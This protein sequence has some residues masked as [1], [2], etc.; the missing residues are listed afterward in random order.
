M[1]LRAK[2]V[3]AG[4]VIVLIPMLLSTIMMWYLIRRQN[5]KDALHR[6]GQLLEMIR[7]NLEAQ[8]AELLEGMKQFSLDKTFNNQ[9]SLVNQL[10]RKN[11]LVRQQETYKTEITALLEN[12]SRI[13]GY[14][15]LGVF[16]AEDSLFSFIKVEDQKPLMAI[17]S[18]DRQGEIVAKVA[19]SSRAFEELILDDWAITDLGEI[20]SDVLASPAHPE[21][22]HRIDVFENHLVLNVSVPIWDYHEDEADQQIGSLVGYRY[23]DQRLLSRLARQLQAE[24]NFFVT[25]RLYLGTLTEFEEIPESRHQGLQ[26]LV[27]TVDTTERPHLYAEYLKHGEPFYQA[28]LPLVRNEAGTIV[29][30]LVVSLSK[31]STYQNTREVIVLLAWVSCVCL[32]VVV[33]ITFIVTGRFARPIHHIAVVSDSISQGCIDHHIEQIRSQDE[34]G[35]LSRSFHEMVAYLREMAEIATHI[36]HGETVQDLSPTTEQD[37]LGTAF[38]RMITYFKHIVKIAERMHRG[39]LTQRVAVQ[40]TQDVLGAAFNNVIGQLQS[41]VR[42]VR[43]ESRQLADVSGNVKSASEESSRNSLIQTQSVE[44][45][46]SALQEMAVNIESVSENLETQ[47]TAIAH[48]K[49]SARAI[50][51]S[52]EDVANEVKQ[53]TTF[54]EQTASEIEKMDES[55]QDMHKQVQVSVEASEE[56][57]R[58]S[59]E[60]SEQVAQLTDEIHSIHRQ[61]EMAS[62]AILRL[63]QE[64]EHIRGILEVIQDVM[65][66]TNLLALNASIIAAQAGEHGKA[67]GVVAD[68]VK[69]LASRTSESTKEIAEFT[70]TIHT[71]LNDAVN[72]IMV[73]AQY[74]EEGLQ[75]ADKTGQFL[76]IITTGAEQSS[77]LISHIADNVESHSKSSKQVEQASGEVV[78]ML[79]H[80][81]QL[82]EVQNEQSASI[83]QETAHLTD[84]SLEI[85]HAIKEQ[86]TSANQ[87]VETMEDMIAIVQQN[88]KRAEGLAA[89]ATKLSSQ[90]NMLL[91]LVEEFTVDEA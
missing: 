38:Q 70:K 90:A 75:I 59:K 51:S 86:E 4:I 41:L 3:W 1:S 40:S 54:T 65:E 80:I 5:D 37:V 16:G 30:T 79:E 64:S 8:G 6:S 83:H 84:I 20:F 78:K 32:L 22:T 48:V 67:F 49:D 18:Q 23:L 43:T 9:I 45:I 52:S 50:T 89:L 63:Q 26:A 36:S 10:Q 77:L 31:E 17:T 2:L 68:E 7:Q 71:E 55:V 14:D 44:T 91:E 72:A 56:V 28:Y 53:V 39:D 85:Q 62:D 57:V 34:I 82:T 73:S 25:S 76:E 69:G 35:L 58:V 47:A 61:M 60:G 11:V 81:A 66:Q 88:A 87:S 15:V 19:D 74:V 29:S 33:P 12:F 27:D 42:F 13:G 21:P 46:T 24:V